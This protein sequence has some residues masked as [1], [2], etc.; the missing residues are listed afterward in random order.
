[1]TWVIGFSKLY[2]RGLEDGSGSKPTKPHGKKTLD[3]MSV[4]K[5]SHI[6]KTRTKPNPK[7]ANAWAESMIMRL[8]SNMKAMRDG[9]YSRP[10]DA[11]EAERMW[12]WW[13]QNGDGRGE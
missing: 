1:M 12:G 5:V 13:G 8:L 10:R 11:K 7:E 3:D 4:L 2:Q 9:R 6:S